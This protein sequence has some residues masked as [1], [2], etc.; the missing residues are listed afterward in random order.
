VS[1]SLPAAPTNLSA[2]AG[3]GQVTLHWS[4]SV[5]ATSY[6]I[7]RAHPAGVEDG[8]RI[9][10][11]WTATSFTDTGLTNGTPYSYFVKADNGAGEGP[12]SSTVSATPHGSGAQE[13]AVQSPLAK[14][15]TVF[16]TAGQW[17]AVYL[18]GVEGLEE[19]ARQL[20]GAIRGK[21][22][23]TGLAEDEEGHQC[24]AAFV[25]G[26][27]PARE[28]ERLMRGAGLSGSFLALPARPRTV[29][30]V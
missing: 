1:A 3:D 29:R 6:N 5:G 26:P 10:S 21:G 25:R 30:R 11:N 19:G 15:A 22:H 12:R 9:R 23:D 20:R 16:E 24:V 8:A 2:T 28:L 13:T 14:P 17:F 4:P 7:Y 18:A 27:H